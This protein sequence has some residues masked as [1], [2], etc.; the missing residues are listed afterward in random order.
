MALSDCT[1]E[2]LHVYHLLTEFFKLNMPVPIN[3]DKK[4]A[5]HIAENDWQIEMH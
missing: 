5:G 4:G 2:T 3:I 1:R